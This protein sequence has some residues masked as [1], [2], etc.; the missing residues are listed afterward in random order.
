MRKLI[1][2][3][4]VPVKLV[5]VE[6]S[7]TF[8]YVEE[9][10]REEESYVAPL[11]STGIELK[12]V[13]HI[14]ETTLPDAP[15]SINGGASQAASISVTMDPVSKRMVDDL[16][17]SELNDNGEDAEFIDHATNEVPH[18][19]VDPRHGSSP[20]KDVG[21]ETSYGL[22]GTSMAREHFGDLQGPVSN[23]PRPHLPSIINSPFALQPGEETPGSRPSTAKGK[24]PSHSQQNSQT[25]FPLQRQ[26]NAFSADSSPSNSS[27]MPD[28]TAPNSYANAFYRH[29][30]PLKDTFPSAQNCTRGPRTFTTF[31]DN[32]LHADEPNFLSLEVFEGSTWGGSDQSGR[33]ATNIMTPPNGQGAG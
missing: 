26:P 8:T 5:D 17:D 15:I 14:D 33:K 6:G 23:S 30:A 31:R 27:T 4:K 25:R 12:E 2:E 24:T 7:A 16:V 32:P 20:A 21:D 29:Q 10:M 13:T 22:I 18:S 3:Q 11:S 9:G 19:F 28:P 1:G